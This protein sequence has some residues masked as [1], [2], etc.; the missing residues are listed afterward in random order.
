MDI[1]FNWRSFNH[2]LGLRMKQDAQREVRVLAEQM[3][4]LVKSIPG[5]PFKHTLTAFNHV[6]VPEHFSPPY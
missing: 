6:D 3:L 1:M 5:A 2:F 4:D